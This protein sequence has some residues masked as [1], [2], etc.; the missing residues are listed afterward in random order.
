MAYFY[1]VLA[2]NILF[3]S[4]ASTGDWNL[5]KLVEAVAKKIRQFESGRQREYRYFPEGATYGVLFRQIVSRNYSNFTK[6][7]LRNPLWRVP[8]FFFC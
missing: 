3:G 8:F 4:T 2:Y 5:I 7:V 6:I 1:D